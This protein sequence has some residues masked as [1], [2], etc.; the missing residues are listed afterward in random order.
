[1]G[2]PPTCHDLLW[3]VPRPLQGSKSVNFYKYTTFF[4]LIFFSLDTSS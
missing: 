1:M 3:A 4:L 2:I